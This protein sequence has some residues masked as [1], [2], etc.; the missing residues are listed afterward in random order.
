MEC[1]IE[2]AIGNSEQCP[3]E[4]CPFWERGSCLL[5]RRLGGELKKRDIA[6]WLVGVRRA[7]EEMRTSEGGLQ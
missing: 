1:T 7:L 4:A 3:G 2:K 5:T 6:A